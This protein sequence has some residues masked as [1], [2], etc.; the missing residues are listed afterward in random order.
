MTRMYCRRHHGNRDLCA[1]CRRLLDY[2]LERLAR[3]PF[4]EAKP[5]CRRCPVHCYAP[6]PRAAIR[7]IMRWAGPRMLFR[8]PRLALRHLLDE[9]RR[10]QDRH[11]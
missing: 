1:D 5:S 6:E 4:G 11:R 3:C 10:T 7:A 8:H 9:R 2:A